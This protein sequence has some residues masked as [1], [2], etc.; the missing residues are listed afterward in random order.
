MDVMTGPDNKDREALQRLNAV[1]IED[2][3]ATSDEEILAEAAQ[4]GLDPEAIAAATRALFE[5]AVAAKEKAR[6]P[7]SEDTNDAEANPPTGVTAAEVIPLKPTRAKSKPGPDFYGSPLGMAAAPNE[8]APTDQPT[9]LIH[10]GG[11]FE[12]G[13]NRYR[14]A[15][16]TIDRSIWVVGT[17]PVVAKYIV[18]GQQRYRLA[19]APDTIDQVCVQGLGRG[20]AEDLLRSKEPFRFDPV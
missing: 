1:M 5:K 16:S 12:V 18:V 19:A 10:F 8:T 11:D 4:D 2:I 13:S 15:Q 3:L 9:R 7:I 17:I 6:L 14:F 20:D